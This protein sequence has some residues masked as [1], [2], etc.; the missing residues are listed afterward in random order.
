MVCLQSHGMSVSAE[1]VSPHR[2]GLAS[3]EELTV[4]QMRTRLLELFLQC[5]ASDKFNNSISNDASIP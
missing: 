4:G 3:D 1:L 2:V 5:R